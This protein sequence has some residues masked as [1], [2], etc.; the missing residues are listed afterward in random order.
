[1]GGVE[2]KFWSAADCLGWEEAKIVVKFSAVYGEGE[3]GGGQREGGGNI[4]FEENGS[5]IMFKFSDIFS[6]SQHG[7]VY[8]ISGGWR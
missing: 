6:G 3:G 4:D 5:S 1:M 2:A 8:V 7:R